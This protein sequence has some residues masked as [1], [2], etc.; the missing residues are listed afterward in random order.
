ML[1]E[2][3]LI[4]KHLTPKRNTFRPFALLSPGNSNTRIPVTEIWRFPTP[5]SSLLCF[6]LLLS[7][8]P[9][10]S[11]TS[12]PTHKWNP[13]TKS[14]CRICQK[15]E[16]QEEQ[17]NRPSTGK[18]PA[19]GPH[20]ES[21]WLDN[22]HFPCLFPLPKR[23]V[24]PYTQTTLSLYTHDVRW[25]VGIDS[26]VSPCLLTSCRYHIYTWVT[27]HTLRCK[28]HPYIN[29]PGFWFQCQCYK[30]GRKM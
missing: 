4:S 9:W 24:S 22:N 27:V 12:Y 30:A 13:G 6:Q 25:F 20:L 17:R 16:G 1:P 5:S 19:S 14:G 15:K 3:L 28:K 7:A 21:R 10:G 11:L 29:Q 26:T 2:I 23:C 8:F 18:R